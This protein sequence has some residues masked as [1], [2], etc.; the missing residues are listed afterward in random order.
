MLQDN[1]IKFFEE[2][3]KEHSDAPGHHRLL[4]QRGIHLLHAG[5]GGRQTAHAFRRMRSK[6]GRQSGRRGTEQPAVGSGLHRNAHLRQY[7]RSHH[8][9]FRCERHQP[10][11]RPFARPS[12][13]SQRHLLGHRRTRQ[14]PPGKGR[15]LA[16]GLPVPLRTRRR[17]AD[18]FPTRH[19]T[20]LQRPVPERVPAGRHI[21]RSSGTETRGRNML[22]FGNDR[23]QQ[24]GNAH[25]G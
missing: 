17:E 15:V 12:A 23:F 25:G 11:H 16:L 5:A 2:S 7:R 22:H 6:R 19:P 9:G 18:S 3:F 14:R 8:A 4:H 21:V 10:H 24:G 13:L 1:L 20:P